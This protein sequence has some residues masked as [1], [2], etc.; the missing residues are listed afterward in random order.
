LPT[1]VEVK[2]NPPYFLSLTAQREN[3]CNA[4]NDTQKNKTI[5]KT[6]LKKH[7]MLSQEKYDMLSKMEYQQS[8]DSRY[9]CISYILKRENTIYS[10]T[11]H[12]WPVC[13]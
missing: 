11:G 1:S 9:L 6:P 4:R 7:E 13:E 3:T 10:D 12:Q 8:K 2:F 5:T